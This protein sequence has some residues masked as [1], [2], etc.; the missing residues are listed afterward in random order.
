M[1]TDQGRY[2]AQYP[3]QFAVEYPD[4]P[5][6]RLI[7]SSGFSWIIPIAIVLGA[8]SGCDLGIRGKQLHLT[9]P[10]Q[11]VLRPPRAQAACCSSPRC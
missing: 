4:R 5:L 8:V 2:P 1:T 3:V 6:S 10:L 9:P 7:R 11:H